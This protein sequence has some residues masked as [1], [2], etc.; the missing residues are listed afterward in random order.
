MKATVATIPPY[1]GA[2]QQSS[3]TFS[4][5]LPQVRRSFPATQPLVFG[6]AIV[7]GFFIVFLT[8][9]HESAAQSA[10]M[11]DSRSCKT[12]ETVRI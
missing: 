9:W 8:E 5:R 7:A 11:S 1:L 6:L 4:R 3:A 12:P 10:H 2:P